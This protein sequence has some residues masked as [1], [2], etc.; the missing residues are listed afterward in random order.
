MGNFLGDFSENLLEILVTK[1][2]PGLAAKFAN[3][4]VNNFWPNG[5]SNIVAEVFLDLDRDDAWLSDRLVM[6][7]WVVQNS[8][9]R[10]SASFPTFFFLDNFYS[11]TAQSRDSTKYKTGHGTSPYLYVT[12]RN[13]ISLISASM[14]IQEQSICSTLPEGAS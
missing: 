12:R 11:G 4:D 10:L 3:N 7:E 8:Y 5:L 6:S 14:E 2:V 1:W 9:S 13:P